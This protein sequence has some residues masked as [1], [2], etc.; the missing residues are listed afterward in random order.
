MSAL[1]QSRRF[2]PAQAMSAF[3]PVATR[4]RT[5]SDVRYVPAADI[6]YSSKRPEPLRYASNRTRPVA[7]SHTAPT[8]FRRPSVIRARPSGVSRI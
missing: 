5:F 4:E 6:G 2:R 1:G 8:T 7:I 3:P